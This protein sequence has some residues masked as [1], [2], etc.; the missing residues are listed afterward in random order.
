MLNQLIAT[1]VAEVLAAAAVT[2][3]A[4]T[5]EETNLGPNSSQN[6]AG[7]YKIFV[8]VMHEKL[9]GTEG[10]VGL[11]RWFEKLEP[12]FGIS[13]VAEGDR[14]KFA[15]STLLDSA[16]TWWNVYVR[17]VTL[18]TAHA[19]PWS[20]FKAMFIRKYCP[21]NE[22]KQMENKLWNL[23]L[24]ENSGDKQKWNGNHYNN[25]NPNTTSNLNL[26]KRPETTRVFIA[27]Q[28][29]YDISQRLSSPTLFRRDKGNQEPWRKG[30]RTHSTLTEYKLCAKA[31]MKDNNVLNG[32]FLINNVYASVLFDTGADRSV[33]SH[34]F[35]KYIDIPPTTLDTNYSV[36][37]AEA[38]SQLGSF[39][40][41]IGMDWMAEH[42]AE[43]VCYEKYIRV[44]Y[45]N[46]MMIVQGERSGVK[47]ESRLEVISSIRKQGDFPEV[48]PEDLLGLPLTRQI[49]FHIELIPEAAPVAR[50]PYR[51]VPAEMKE[52]AEQLKELSNKGFIRPSSS[53][54]GAPILFVKK[55]DGS[56][57]MCIDYR[58]L[59]K[60]TVKNRYPLPRIDDLFDQLQ[61]SSIYS[62]IDLRSGYHQLRV[63][64]ED[65]PKTAFRTRYGHYE[66]RVMPFGLTNAPAV[67]MD[68]MNRVCK[69]YLD[70]FVIVFID[71][72]LIYSRNEKEH[73]EHLKTILELLKKEELYA[74]FSKCEFWINTVKFLGHV[75][76]S[77]GIHVDPAK[78]EA[79]KNWASPTTPS[80][81]RQFLGL[82]GYYR[83][84]IEGFSKI[85]KPMTELTQ[86]NQ[87]FDWGEEQEEAF[88]LLK[89]KL[90]VAP[91]LALPEG[92]DDFVVYCDASIKG[93]G[94]VL[95]QR[96][97]VIAYASR[98]LKIHEKNYTTHDLELG[99][100]VFALKIW[101]H[102]LYGTKC[103][104]FTDHKSLQ[105][106][107]DQKD[108]NMRQRRWIE[109]LSDYDCEIRYHPGKA[110]VVADA[111]SRKERI[112]P[113]RV[114]ALV[115]TIGLDLTS[116]IL[117]AQKEAVKVEN[118]KAEDIGSMLNRLE[119]RT[120]G[121]LCLDNRS[122]LPCYGDTRSLI[123]HESHKSKYSIHLGCDKMYHDMK[124]LY[125]PSGLL[126]QPDIPEWKWE[127][128]T[129][130]FITKLPKTAAGFDSIW[131]IVDRLTKSA[132][133]LPMKE[134]DST[135]KLT[136][137]Y[138]K[139]I[140]ERHYGQ[141]E[142]T[143]Q[144][145]EDMLRAYV[146]DFG[147]GWDRHLPLV[148]F[149]Y[150]NSYH[151]SIK[152]AP[153]KA[154]DGRKYRLPVC[155]AKVGEAQ[156]TGPEIIHETTEKIFKIRDRMQAARD[157]QKSYAD[158][159]RRPLEF[160][161]G[162]K[163][164]LKVAPWKGVIRFGKRGKLNPRYIGPFQIIERIGPVAYRLELP[165]ELSRVH[166]VFHVCNLKKCLS[167]DTLV[168]PLEEIQ[169]DDKLNFVEE[170]VEI[171]DRE[172]KQLKRSRIP[173]VKVRWNA[174][175]GPEYTWERE[176][177]F[178]SKYPY[179][180]ANPQSPTSP[181]EP[182]PDE[183]VGLYQDPVM[184]DKRLL[185]EAHPNACQQAVTGCCLVVVVALQRDVAT[186]TAVE[187]AQAHKSTLWGR[188]NHNSGTKPTVR[189]RL[190]TEK[191]KEGRP[192]L[193]DHVDDYT[194]ME[195][196]SAAD[197][198]L[199][200][201]SV[202]EAQA[203]RLFGNKNVWVEMHRGIT[204]DKVENLDPQSAPQVLPSFEEYTLPVTYPEE[205][206]ET[207]GIPIEVEPLDHT[208]LEDL[209][210]NTCSHD[211]FL[212]SREILNVDE[213]KP[214]LLPNFSPL[215]V[216]LEDKRG[217][218]P[219][220]KPHSP[221]SFRMKVVDK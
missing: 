151:T 168:I 218:D 112:E 216:N 158:K 181:K 207:L 183:L 56:F 175:R 3:A 154:L 116:R 191:G 25:N 94:A 76:D 4:S 52:L 109:L 134:T 184:R 37:L 73:E 127:K 190:K 155:W 96:M 200:E 64:E 100:V 114:R 36:E 219:P 110:N 78:I 152:V 177:Q 145:L 88:Q 125:W 202:E 45:G 115:M 221:D 187:P 29:S 204:W 99:A 146:I 85:A 206:E 169:L 82:A 91:I 131:V 48:F 135:K 153:F 44:P 5:E 188:R 195:L 172:V 139:E 68:L 157:R 16:L 49:E 215:D 67:F 162:D 63:R 97:K 61:G 79:V 93:L 147:N 142:R 105:H 118:I 198:N 24:G 95:M 51:L 57:W 199:R 8:A 42:H 69:P 28:G 72:I 197:G 90:C 122:W 129:M 117:E 10:A 120:D 35:S 119:A 14:V 149:S 27:G 34:A 31:A 159:R 46:D 81:I 102:Y 160:E 23:K 53:P 108:L 123:M 71:D 164:M 59:N 40:V 209:G 21:R 75:I 86:K 22:V 140:V 7:K 182:E 66:F 70:K 104:V 217:T 54:W 193:Y 205:V 170:P 133:F 121:T 103:V 38:G 47:N 18:D 83:R 50:A 171:M 148:E 166:N 214:Q 130:D 111:L 101:R 167:D 124:M 179:L 156:L 98:Q 150:N 89:Q 173:I 65:I 15:S 1:R 60:L 12:Q 211:I 41:I 106:I 201:L 55:K 185:P 9:C 20:D 26:N 208:K 165:Q 174:R 107:L 192:F 138:M 43:V 84:F 212:S 163:V 6:K 186:A 213:L 203:K 39:D 137:L 189:T 58:E 143:I 220:I 176:D 77:S 132:H 210:L 126:V 87:K 178:K 33:V 128:I 92:S 80:E 17:S 113:L 136:R 74:K 11:T 19:T 180:F 144:T 13:N 196:D 2:H 32:T 30:K 62:K 161:V 194:R 141:S